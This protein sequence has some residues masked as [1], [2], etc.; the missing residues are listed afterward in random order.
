MTFT[1]REKFIVA[2]TIM[3]TSKWAKKFPRSVRQSLLGYI[4]SNEAPTVSDE[5]WH[6]IAQGINDHVKKTKRSFFLGFKDAFTNP[7]KIQ[8]SPELTKLDREVREE[9]KSGNIDFDD[10]ETDD[11]EVKKLLSEAKSLMR[12]YENKQD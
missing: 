6:E 1:D 4:R 7:F 3:V 5:E 9:L 12:D 8:G 11:P 10:V 2:S